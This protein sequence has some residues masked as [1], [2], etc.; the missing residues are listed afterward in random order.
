MATAFQLTELIALVSN[1]T[2]ARDDSGEKERRG[3]E[4][5][6]SKAID[7]L[8]VMLGEAARCEVFKA[9]SSDKEYKEYLFA[10]LSRPLAGRWLQIAASSNS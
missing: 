5:V 10:V 4:E 3:F 9:I 7:R 1:L 2:V 8:Y 6:K